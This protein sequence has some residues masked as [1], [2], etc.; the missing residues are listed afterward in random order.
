MDKCNEGAYSV[1]ALLL[2]GLVLCITSAAAVETSQQPCQKKQSHLAPLVLTLPE[3]LAALGH[4]VQQLPDCTAQLQQLL[5]EGAWEELSLADVIVGTGFDLPHLGGM[6]QLDLTHWYSHT[7]GQALRSQRGIDELAHSQAG[8]NSSQD[9]EQD[10]QRG[11]GQGN[12]DSASS[13]LNEDALPDGCREYAEGLH[14][15]LAAAMAHWRSES[16]EL[17][18]AD[19]QRDAQRAA[20][21][22]LLR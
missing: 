19:A 18:K 22:E 14:H 5:G 6:S 4:L 21:L 1:S 8:S 10:V 13:H 12:C 7:L 11:Q 9:L 2:E 20:L 15:R 3:A 17:L 16:W